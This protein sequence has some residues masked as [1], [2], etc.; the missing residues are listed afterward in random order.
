MFNH[1]TT[2]EELFFDG[3]V[4]W[5]TG[6][7]AAVRDREPGLAPLHALRGY[8][9]DTVAALVGSMALPGAPLLPGH[10]GGL[11]RAAGPGAGAGPRVRAAA[12]RGAAGGVVEPDAAESPA[13]PAH[14]R[15]A[16][17]RRLAGRRPRHGARAAPPGHR[18]V[19]PDRAAAAVQV[20]ADRLLAQMEASLELIN[21]AAAPLPRDR[22]RLARGAVLRAG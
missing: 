16:D 4:P 13:D 17:R 15:P 21:G 2:K 8:L 22:H 20:F 5:V 1:F 19:E 18:R 14:R 11:R 9:I 12:G 3:R 7:A 10:P 6:P